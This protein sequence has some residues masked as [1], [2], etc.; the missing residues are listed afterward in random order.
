MCLTKVPGTDNKSLIIVN[1]NM[2]PK[3]EI[4]E[5]IGELICREV[6]KPEC[7]V[8]ESKGESIKKRNGV[9]YIK[10]FRKF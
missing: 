3:H 8:I 1:Q 7:E 5:R 6:G 9:N 4:I 10:F 2:S